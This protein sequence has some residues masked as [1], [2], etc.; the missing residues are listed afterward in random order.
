MTFFFIILSVVV[1]VVFFVYS[2]RTTFENGNNNTDYNITKNT[3][4]TKVTLTDNG[5]DNGINLV[6]AVYGSYSDEELKWFAE[7]SSLLILHENYKEKINFLRNVNPKIILLVYKFLGV[8]KNW[9]EHGCGDY[10]FV[11]KKEEWFLHDFF[12]RR[13]TDQFNEYSKENVF[14]LD[15]RNKD[16]VNYCSENFLKT[17]EQGWDGIFLD[18]IHVN[19]GPWWA[20]SGVL[21]YKNNEEFN[22]A[23][24]EFLMNIYPKFQ[25]NKK[26]LILNGPEAINEKGR[27]ELWLEYSDGISDEGFVNIYGWNPKIFRSEEEWELQMQNLETTGRKEKIYIAVAHN[28]GFNKRELFYNLASFL[29]GKTSEKSFF[30][31]DGARMLVDHQVKFDSILKDYS[32]FDYIYKIK[33]GHPLSLKYKKD[34]V[35]QRDYSNGKVL[36]NPTYQSYK[37]NLGREYKTLDGAT[38]EEIELKEHEG[39]I[40][41]SN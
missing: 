5:A 15:Y 17:L 39:I 9:A 33:I 10:S 12:G 22:N 8:N 21:E 31:N 32:L 35:W 26:L 19:I 38:V 16:F 6:Y 25:T 23:I 4:N 11:E 41:L 24:L 40:L 27:W 18:G 34:G 13:I 30:Y 3:N 36:V 37:I 1:L 14:L 29:I 28:S 2:S 20:P 7:H